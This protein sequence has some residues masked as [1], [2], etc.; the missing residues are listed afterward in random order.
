MGVP[1]E[2][3]TC[4][5]CAKKTLNRSVSRIADYLM[6]IEKDGFYG[7]LTVHVAGGQIKRI[8]INEDFKPEAL[9]KK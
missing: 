7:N 5:V 9:V 1:T 4:L 8:T 2:G 6:E 3:F